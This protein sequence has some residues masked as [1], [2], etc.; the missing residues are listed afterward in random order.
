M[1]T[2]ESGYI[3]ECARVL[4]ENLLDTFKRVTKSD[5][6]QQ[7]YDQ[8]VEPEQFD[9]RDE[10]KRSKTA[11]ENYLKRRADF[12]YKA[13]V[14]LEVREVV[15]SS[16]EEVNDPNSKDF[17]R[18]MSAKQGNDAT[19]IYVHDHSLRRTKVNETRNFS[20]EANANFYNLPTSSIA[21][22][23]HIPTPLYDRNPELLRK[24][25]W[26]EIDEIYR[27]HREETRDLAFQLF[28][29]ES[30]YMRFFP[31]ASWYINAA[32]NSKN[33]LIMLDMSGSMLGQRYEIAKQ[34]TEAILETLSHNDYFNIMPFSKT[35]YFLDDCNGKNGLLQATMRNKK[36]PGHYELHTREEMALMEPN[37]TEDRIHVVFPEHVLSADPAYIKAISSHHG[38]SD[39]G[40]ENVIMLIT[41]GA[42]NVYKEIFDLYNKDK[43][44][45]FFSF[46]IGEEAIDFEQVKTMACTNRGYM[47][48]VQNMA[49]V[50]D[51]VQHYIRTMSRP[52]GQNAAD[53]Q[54]DDALWSG[55]YRERL[56]LPRPE[57]FAEPVP[58]TN[59]SKIRLQ[60]TE[61]RG[62]MFVTTVSF[63]VIV[64]RTFMGVAAVNTP[65]TE[66]NQQAHPSNI[67]PRSYFFMLDQN[68]FIMFHPQ[69]RPI[70]PATKSHKQN[71]NNMDLLELEVPQTQQVLSSRHPVRKMVMN[72]DNSDPQLLDVLFATEML[73]RVY[74]QTN[75]YFS[76]CIQ[77]ANFVLGL[78][79]AKGDDYR[80]RSKSRQY[81]YSRV[82]LSW[83]GDKQWKEEAFV[84]YAT[85]MKHSGKL[86][87]LCRP[88]EQLVNKLL[89]DLEAT[90]ALQDSWD[91]QWQFLKDNLIHLVFFATPSGLIRFYN[92]TLDDYDYE[93]PNWSI[94]DHIGAM[95]S[96]EHVQESYNHFITDL[97][98]K[99]VDDTYYRRSVR[100]KDHIV[101]DVSNKSKIWYKSE[102]QL[103]AYGL[104]EN[105]TMLAQGTKAI[106]LGN[107]LL[108]HGCA[109]SDDRRWCV[110]LD[111]HGYVFYSNQRDISYEDYLEDPVH[112]GKHISQWF[113]SINRVSQRVMSLLVEKRFYIK[114]KYTDHQAMCKEKKV[115][116]MSSSSLRPF[117]S[118]YRWLMSSIYRL[119]LLAK[120]YPLLHLFHSFAKPVE[121]YT[122]SFH[123]G[124]DGF[125]CSKQS[126]FYLANGDGRSRPQSTSLVDMNRSDRPCTLNSA[127]CS[128]KMQASFVEGTNLVMVWIIQDKTSDNCY[129]E[130]QCPKVEP[131]EVPFGFERVP[132]VDPS[133]KCNGEIV[134]K[135]TAIMTCPRA[136][137][138]QYHFNEN[139]PPQMHHTYTRI[140][141]NHHIFR[142]DKMMR[143]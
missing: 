107:A 46:L 10:L 4:S 143:R 117:H 76:E 64:N 132:P 78:A 68:G 111:E 67:G 48:H 138:I 79:V 63:P 52:I 22:A 72:C 33:V 139:S 82:Q 25:E 140:L 100:M 95:L 106:Y 43:K 54:V 17:I 115:V 29:S 113:G 51:K 89:L 47:V 66:L 80:W 36:L 40:C 65:L 1:S 62:R 81:D 142:C 19:T 15:N 103:T 23:V 125:P 129:D 114:L 38:R 31:A 127:K 41:D 9:P 77:G 11:V 50:E 18:F 74:P 126:Y 61:A 55:V 99:S 134:R 128:V 44:V 39:Q 93:D 131:S 49:D 58:I 119:L 8:F 35:P 84:I 75:V 28:C 3:E 14:S 97:N 122:A 73:D 69:L 130:T 123:E 96:I 21:S 86:P 102:T 12:A 98:R 70:D 91:L 13:K 56:Y 45:R 6:I 5:Q 120:Q 85:Q 109:P 59:Q 112:K 53:I 2:L 92:Q 26:S 20:L 94:F 34:T 42:P 37:S 104:N 116:V 90:S 60:K 141:K 57:T 105:L 16:D 101:F 32:T 108:E 136:A 24:I 7:L 87:A 133:E 135:C 124:T 118:F 30:G 71:Y 27:T 88:R 137:P 110:L 121:S 83:M